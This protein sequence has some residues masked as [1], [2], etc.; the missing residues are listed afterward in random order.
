MIGTLLGRQPRLFANI[1]ATD[2][3][4]AAGTADRG[5]PDSDGSCSHVFLN[6]RRHAETIIDVLRVT[7][8]SCAPGG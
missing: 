2:L 4:A 6:T 3:A 7:D 1:A 8:W 5:S